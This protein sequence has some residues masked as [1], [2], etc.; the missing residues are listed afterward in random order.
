MSFEQRLQ[1]FQAILQREREAAR[2][3]DLG[4]MM[5][6]GNIRIHIR[7]DQIVRDAFDA[8]GAIDD[9]RLRKRI[10]GLMFDK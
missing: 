2:G 10:Q 4:M 6:P 8:L 3:A 1:L 9:H 7:R 5:M